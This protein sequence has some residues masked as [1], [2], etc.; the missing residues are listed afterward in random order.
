MN[1]NVNLL[2]TGYSIIPEIVLPCYS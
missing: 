1:R 2:A